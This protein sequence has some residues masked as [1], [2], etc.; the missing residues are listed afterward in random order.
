MMSCKQPL[1]VV[2]EKRAVVVH[3]VEQHAQ[4]LRA[5]Q[6]GPR[7]LWQRARREEHLAQLQQPFAQCLLPL[8]GT[9]EWRAATSTLRDHTPIVQLTPRIHTKRAICHTDHAVQ[10]IS[11]A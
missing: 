10:E 3:D 6:L 2:R 4:A 11:V 8:G 9:Q 1:L 7:L 5:C